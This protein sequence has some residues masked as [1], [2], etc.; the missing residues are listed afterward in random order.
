M[1]NDIQRFPVVGTS[2]NS[3]NV[4]LA[5]TRGTPPD[6]RGDGGG[7]RTPLGRYGSGGESSSQLYPLPADILSTPNEDSHGSPNQRL[8]TI[9]PTPSMDG[10]G[11]SGG[12]SLAP[13]LLLQYDAA[14]SVLY[15]AL[16]RSQPRP[17]SH[18]AILGNTKQSSIEGGDRME[19]G[20]SG[21]GDT[22]S[23]SS[24]LPPWRPSTM[25]RGWNLL[26]VVVFLL[27]L[28]AWFSLNEATGAQTERRMAYYKQQAYLFAQRRQFAPYSTS[29]RPYNDPKIQYIVGKSNPAEATIFVALVNDACHK[30]KEGP[31]NI[32]K[33]KK[34]PLSS[35]QLGVVQQ[36]QELEKE[37]EDGR[38]KQQ[39]YQPS[40]PPSYMT[41]LLMGK[42]VD[43]DHWAYFVFCFIAGLLSAIPA[44]IVIPV[45]NIKCRLQ[46]GVY[47]EGFVQGVRDLCKEGVLDGLAAVDSF[48]SVLMGSL[49]AQHANPVVH[50]EEHDT[51]TQ[52][53]S[54]P[55][56]P[57]NVPPDGAVA[58]D[59]LLFVHGSKTAAPSISKG[60]GKGK[61]GC[62]D[63][64]V[65]SLRISL[66]R[67]LRPVLVAGPRDI[68]GV[69][70]LLS[71]KVSV[72]S[73]LRI[74][75]PTFSTN[76]SLPTPC[77][78]P[79]RAVRLFARSAG[80]GLTASSLKKAVVDDVLHVG[81]TAVR[82]VLL[83]QG[84]LLAIFA[85]WQPVCLGYALQG[86]IKYG[87]YEFGKFKLGRIMGVEFVVEHHLFIFFVSAMFAEL[88]ADL[89]LA[90]WESIKIRL[91]MAKRRF[92]FA[93]SFPVIL[94]VEGIHE[95]YRCLGP[96]I[97]RQVPV[98]SVKF[99]SYESIV[100][101]FVER[102]H[103]LEYL[104]EVQ[105]ALAAGCTAGVICAIMT[106]PADTMVSQVA[107]LRASGGGDV[108]VWT[109][110]K[111]L[112]CKRLYDGLVP[113]LVMVAM[114][115]AMQWGIYDGFKHFVGLPTTGSR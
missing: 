10:G 63:R 54:N 53:P 90:P 30:I 89:L 68:E 7:G 1:L 112:G 3:N 16:S 48:Q 115:T 9:P 109:L 31:S 60:K 100:R 26:L 15:P 83:A 46:V 76:A 5:T 33:T 45:D 21:G 55:T 105:V 38:Q 80:L 14:F 39:Q 84:F 66:L 65:A 22:P 88:S 72:L 75:T 23:S 8:D 27:A 102:L 59:G 108:S 52:H 61:S 87:F 2:S 103:A 6:E 51:N 104:S 97:C 70:N 41:P 74:P 98:T 43:G 101:F 44:I 4:L 18:N 94:H 64:L 34:P 49:Q 107:Q 12:G 20:G 35:K 82:S 42:S 99:V 17:L 113:R 92:P 95:L 47:S 40:P 110:I 85:G 37:E 77:W 11:G 67:A 106:Q 19:E 32:K 71:S 69:R 91:Q 58:D 57:V 114:L 28:V 36:H 96:V 79:L 73:S 56:S 81:L 13:S 93:V 29:I 86:A 50:E 111:R 25:R 24:S 78:L 62:V